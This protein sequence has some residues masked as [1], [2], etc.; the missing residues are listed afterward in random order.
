MTAHVIPFPHAA[1]RRPVERTGMEKEQAL[2]RRTDAITERLIASKNLVSWAA[3][4]CRNPFPCNCQPGK[5]RP[6]GV[7]G[8]TE[9]VI[10]FRPACAKE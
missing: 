7:V 3:E 9:R 5:R 4:H 2:A 8:M 1:K 10:S 6:E